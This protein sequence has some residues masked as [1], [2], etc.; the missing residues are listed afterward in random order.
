[1][2]LFSGCVVGAQTPCRHRCFTILSVVTS[3]CAICT[4]GQQ[5][6]DLSRLFAITL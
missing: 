2:S 4:A 5:V 3:G 1:M 6:I